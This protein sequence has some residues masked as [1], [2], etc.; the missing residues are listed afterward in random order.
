MA[1]MASFLFLLLF[2]LLFA[3]FLGAEFSG[4]SGPTSVGLH[5]PLEA[6][7]P[8]GAQGRRGHLITLRGLL[9]HGSEAGEK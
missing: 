7:A 3:P 4:R 8:S 5:L 9:W 6:Q 1:L 2:L